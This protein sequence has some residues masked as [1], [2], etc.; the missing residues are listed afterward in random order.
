MPSLVCLSRLPRS[1]CASPPIDIPISIFTVQTVSSWS[2]ALWG[3]VPYPGSRLV[4]TLLF[5][6]IV[7]LGATFAVRKGTRNKVLA[8]LATT[9]GIFLLVVG[10]LVY[11]VA[12]RGLRFWEMVCA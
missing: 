9:I 12:F 6:L 1:P 7:V 4:Y 3:N 10:T 2:D 8:D 11:T 5:M